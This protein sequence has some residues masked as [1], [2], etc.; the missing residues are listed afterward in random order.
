MLIEALLQKARDGDGAAFSALVEPLRPSLLSFCFRMLADRE[1]AEDLCQEALLAAY[2][3]I[4][5][6]GEAA[7]FKAWLF[8]HAARL[9]AQATQGTQPW[10]QS[11]LDVL[12]DYLLE[13]SALE[14]ELRA[15]L[16]ENEEEYSVADHVDFCFSVIAQS[17]FPQERSLLLLTR[18]HGF[19]DPEAAWITESRVEEA[20]E[21]RLEAG[22]ELTEA[23][24]IRCGLAKAG[25][26]CTQCRDFGAWL[27]GDEAVEEDLHSLPLKP[28]GDAEANFERRLQL[29]SRVDPLQG[30]SSRFHAQLMQVLRRAL[31]EKGLLKP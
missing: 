1:A 19:S 30:G 11:A 2:S 26:A 15:I 13:H 29:V 17:L 8:R 5:A 12:Q 6:C 10:G 23:L 20:S 3:E 25:A 21:K 22:E 4:A 7:T 16:E 27:N 31:G 28:T 24:A 9:L 18:I 14:D